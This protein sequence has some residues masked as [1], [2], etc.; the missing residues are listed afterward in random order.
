MDPSPCSLLSNKEVDTSTETFLNDSLEK[1]NETPPRKQTSASTVTPPPC[2]SSSKEPITLESIRSMSTNHNFSLEAIRFI[3]KD[4]PVDLLGSSMRTEACSYQ[5]YGDLWFRDYAHAAAFKSA[6]NRQLIIVKFGLGPSVK[7]TKQTPVGSIKRERTFPTERAAPTRT[8]RRIAKLAAAD[9]STLIEEDEQ[10]EG[11]GSMKRQLVKRPRLVKSKAVTTFAPLTTEQL[12]KL[13]TY[14][15]THPWLETFEVYLDRVEQV[16]PANKR[17]VLRQARLLVTGNC[18]EY[19]HWDEGVAF[20]QARIK[21]H[22]GTDL[23][24]LLVDADEFEREHGRD[25]GNGKLCVV[26]RVHGPGTMSCRAICLLNIFINFQGGYSGIQS[27]SL[28]TIS[29]TFSKNWSMAKSHHEYM[30]VSSAC[31]WKRACDR[32]L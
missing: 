11:D 9:P 30:H 26:V 27:K 10:E 12:F 2:L 17:N 19:Q 28:S 32:F 14:C 24:Q 22:L 21:I 23:V 31:T 3:M 29:D 6:F 4:Q 18:I 1:T 20:N 15:E 13:K 25:L 5:G 7:K 8:S 16:S